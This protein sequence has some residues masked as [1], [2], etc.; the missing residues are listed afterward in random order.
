MQSCVQPGNDTLAGSFLISGRSIDLTR[1]KQ[2]AERLHLK[3]RVELS[4]RE[5][6]VFD[7]ITRTGHAHIVE[8]WNGSEHFDLH[9]GR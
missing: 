4:G 9:D 2:S 8:A 3:R 1:E 6:V 7:R 5:E